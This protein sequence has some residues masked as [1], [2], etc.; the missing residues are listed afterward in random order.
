MFACTNGRIPIA[1]AAQGVKDNM[2]SASVKAP[3]PS[4]VEVATG[5]CK[6]VSTLAKVQTV[7]REE[8]Y[9]L[10]N[11]VR[12]FVRSA[13]IRNGSLTI[14]SLHTTGAIFIN[15]WQEALVHDVN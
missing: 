15:E 6:V 1:N 12:D 13:G 4:T 11:L 14:S 8:L 3:E 10:T 7:E 9:N 2:A 5:T